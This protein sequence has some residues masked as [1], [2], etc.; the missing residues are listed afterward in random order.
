MSEIIDLMNRRGLERK[1]YDSIVQKLIKNTEADYSYI[2][3]S[4][5]P[6][7]EFSSLPKT[8]YP[9]VVFNFSDEKNR[10]P[11]DW[12]EDRSV[13]VIFKNYASTGADKLHPIP[14]PPVN[15]F[16]LEKAKSISEKCID[17]FF[18]GQLNTPQRAFI[19]KE[20]AEL[21]EKTHFNIV[22]RGNSAFYSGYSI[23]DYS[24]LLNNSKIAICPAGNNTETF[25]ITEAAKC[26][27]IIFT[28]RKPSFLYYKNA[29]LIE[30]TKNFSSLISSLLTKEQDMN[31]IQRD[32]L[33][34]HDRN[35]S[36]EAVFEFCLNKICE[37]PS[38]SI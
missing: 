7:E 34:W 38:I 2:I 30:L 25:R 21:K 3:C 5:P 36:E 23:Q 32:V 20:L 15:D 11:Q 19:Y 1:F 16:I 28:D 6:H 4:T 35:L 27:S 13:N 22:I 9:K 12:I 33:S 8:K 29:P 31:T 17:V 24:E 37:K 18:S 10:T 26:G 14:L